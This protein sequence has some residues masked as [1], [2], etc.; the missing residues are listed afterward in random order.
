MENPKI[1]V[2]VLQNVAEV[3]SLENAFLKEI[4]EEPMSAEAFLRLKEAILQ[5]RITFFAVRMEE[6][7]IGMCSVSPCFST[8]ACKGCGVFDDFYILP[9]HRG[10]GIARR[11]VN[12]AQAWCR[13]RGYASLIVGCSRGD[14]AM[15]HSLGFDTELGM[16]L[17]NNLS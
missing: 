4:G 3:L 11:L 12:A 2:E 7:L 1:A 10:Q 8:F 13:E 9:E 14:A 16:M 17:A 6:R 15:Y 5:Q